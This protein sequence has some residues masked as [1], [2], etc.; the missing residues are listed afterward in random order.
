MPAF[1]LNYPAGISRKFHTTLL[2]LVNILGI[3]INILSLLQNKRDAFR[4]V[5]TSTQ[6]LRECTEEMLRI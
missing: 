5:D 3:I 4:P 2:I 6:I 1:G